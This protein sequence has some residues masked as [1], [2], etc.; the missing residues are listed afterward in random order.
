MKFVI[1]KAPLVMTMLLTLWLVQMERGKSMDSVI[2]ANST[3]KVVDYAIKSKHCK[4]C[5]HWEKEDKT[6]EKYKQWQATKCEANYEGSA[7]SME[8]NA[9]LELFQASLDYKLQ[10][11]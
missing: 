11:T 8:A 2:I 6:S 9:I 4:G 5:I 1:Y 7:E 3:G 10:Y